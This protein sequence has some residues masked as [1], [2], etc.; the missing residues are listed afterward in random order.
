M[1]YPQAEVPSSNKKY[2]TCPALEERTVIFLTEKTLKE[3]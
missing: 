1:L 2:Y 3:L